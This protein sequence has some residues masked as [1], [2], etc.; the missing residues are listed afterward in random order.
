MAGE[1]PGWKKK[2][3]AKV[4]FFFEMSSSRVGCECSGVMLQGQSASGDA[5]S[6]ERV[7][8]ECSDT[9]AV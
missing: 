4:L 7:S 8:F 3:G 9:S 6:L 2:R 1:L 5:L